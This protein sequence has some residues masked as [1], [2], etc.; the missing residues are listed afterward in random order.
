MADKG[1]V[2]VHNA[3]GVRDPI[4]VGSRKIKCM[5]ALHPFDHPHIYLEMGKMNEVLC[6]YCSTIYRFD[7]QLGENESRPK[8]CTL[9]ENT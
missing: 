6:P 5:G 7:P 2:Y 8:G 9:Y 1:A 4:R 3:I